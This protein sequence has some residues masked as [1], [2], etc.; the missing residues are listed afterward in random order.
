MSHPFEQTQNQQPPFEIVGNWTPVDNSENHLEVA[1]TTGDGILA[2]RSTYA[3]QAM[4]FTTPGQ[5]SNLADAISTGS[6]RSFG[7][8]G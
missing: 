5:L 8:N 7:L 4:L 1:Q 6:L 2:V 3:P